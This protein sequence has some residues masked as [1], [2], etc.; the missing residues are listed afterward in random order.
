MSVTIVFVEHILLRR[1]HV[2]HEWVMSRANEWALTRKAHTYTHNISRIHAHHTHTLSHTHTCTHIH[3]HIHKHIHTHLHTQIHTLTPSHR[4]ILRLVFVNRILSRRSHVTYDRVMSRAN[5]SCHL[6][7]WITFYKE[8]V[9]SHMIES[10][11]VRKSNKT[12]VRGWNPIKTKV[13]SHMN[14]SCHV[15][16]VF[17]EQ[18][19]SKKSHITYEWV[20]SRANK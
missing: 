10:C 19:L 20:M 16:I 12:C 1:S 17:V 2:T 18:I 15:W 4:W 11:H 14:E 5:E 6:C 7:W 3:I 9:T 8:E 13:T